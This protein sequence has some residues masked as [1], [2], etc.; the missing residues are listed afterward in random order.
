MH[1]REMNNIEK[2]QIPAITG[3]IRMLREMDVDIREITQEDLSQKEKS[4]IL[5]IH[6]ENKQ[7]EL[8]FLKED[9]RS[10]EKRMSIDG[11]RSSL[12]FDDGCCFAA[13]IISAIELVHEDDGMDGE[14]WYIHL[15]CWDIVD[16]D[17]AVLKTD[18]FNEIR[19]KTGKRILGSKKLDFGQ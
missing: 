8:A 6:L 16:E 12:Y 10:I 17:R 4:D 9:F 18:S 11:D 2:R 15:V 14:G 1:T 5:G 3:K 13:N 7:I 19:R